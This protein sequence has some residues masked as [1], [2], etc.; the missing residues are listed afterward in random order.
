MAYN[1]QTPDIIGK[2]IKNISCEFLA[3]VKMFLDLA[4]GKRPEFELEDKHIVFGTKMGP[5]DYSYPHL[6]ILL[7]D[8]IGTWESRGRY[9]RYILTLKQNGTY[10][11]ALDIDTIFNREE[12]IYIKQGNY[13]YDNIKNRIILLNHHAKH[14]LDSMDYIKYEN[15][16][17]KEFIIV[18]LSEETMTL[19]ESGAYI[20]Q[21]RKQHTFF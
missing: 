2:R 21:Y 5:E 12:I 11:M 3:R 14:E 10:N 7:S 8:I 16:L 13:S 19:V 6:D 1:A 9:V 17:N 18:S 20:T 15:P 4:I